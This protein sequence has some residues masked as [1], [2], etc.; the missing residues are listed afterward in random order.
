MGQ[1]VIGYVFGLAQG[2]D[3]ALE[4]SGVPQDDCGDD[5]IEARGAML[6]V[7][8]GPITDFTEPMDEDR[9][10]KAVAGFALEVAPEI[11]TG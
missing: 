7:L 10:R 8:V 1:Q 9:T 5:Q 11:R 4:I 3:G 6:L 2:G